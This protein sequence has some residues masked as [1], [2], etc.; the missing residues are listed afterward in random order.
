MQNA[1]KSYFT[2]DKLP[3][4]VGE[5]VELKLQDMISQKLILPFVDEDGNSCN[6]YRSY[7]SI[8]KNENDYTLKINLSCNN[9]E[10]FIVETLGC[11]DYC[12]NDICTVEE[13]KVIEYQ[14]KKASQKT[15]ES[16]V[17][18][19]GF[20]PSGS[21]CA[22]VTSNKVG[23]EPVFSSNSQKVYDASIKEGETKTIEV[24]KELVCPD[25]SYTLN[26]T[27]KKCSKTINVQYQGGYTKYECPSGSVGSGSGASLTC[28]TP[29]VKKETCKSV[30][31]ESP[32]SGSQYTPRGTTTEYICN[33][34]RCP[35]WVTIYHYLLCTTT[36]TGGDP[37]PVIKTVIPGTPYCT[38]GSIDA[39]KTKCNI[40][41][42]A[43][44]KCP[45]GASSTG[46][47]ASLKCFIQRKDP[48]TYYCPVK[49]DMLVNK[50]CYH[51]E[52]GKFL[53][54]KC[55]A[56][57]NPDGTYCYKTSSETA[58]KICKAE[59]KTVYTYKWSKEKTLKGWISTGKTRT[60]KK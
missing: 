55:P 40:I 34:S 53:Y 42:T 25:N 5:T 37:V 21:K 58:N 1:A 20:I 51:F 44:E 28:K 23:A 41:K 43:T 49:D 15:I 52:G 13:E 46:S 33:S 30:S 10:D 9:E 60:V 47:G 12:E 57:F 32:K 38:E 18:P 24:S 17:C 3:K 35:G 22:K 4:N 56:G 19:T 7:V 11:Y 39:T 31:Y 54:Y 8:T 26:E 16:C 59:T 36:T 6:V 2:V 45:T 29:V 14:F 27:T 50:K 48:D